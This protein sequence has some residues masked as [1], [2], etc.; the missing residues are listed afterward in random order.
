MP[1]LFDSLTIRGVTLRNRVAYAPMCQYSSTDGFATNW[2]L[3]HL[4]SR[5]VGGAGLVVTEATA[6]LPEGRISPEDL[7]IWQDAHIPKLA[8]IV[9]FVREQ[10]AELC[11]QLAHA[12][13]KASTARPWAGGELLQPEAGGWVVRAPSPLPHDER[14]GMPHELSR[15]E[16]AA[17]V[18]AFVAAAWRGVAAGCRVLEVHAA[19]GYLLHNFL[20][21]LA[22]A[23][24]DEYGG[25]FTGRTRIVREIVAGVRTVMP[26]N[27]ALLV[28]ISASDW[29]EGGWTIDDS[30]A[31]SR[32]LRAL[33]ADVIDCSS[34]GGSP[35]Q[36]IP[37]G[38]GYQVPFAERIRTEAQIATGAVGLI[39]EPA[40]ADAVIR[41]ERADLVLIGRAMMSDPYW[42]IN[43]ASAL[44]GGTDW[45]P[46][47]W[48]RNAALWSKPRTLAS[49]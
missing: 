48:R 49:S 2:H 24:S 32:D 8:E 29:T 22:N 1:G 3:V 7:G 39:V 6:V 43:A 17:T 45:P 15:A 28:R 23:R 46:Q 41:E 20:S 16:I 18:A 10:G 36:Q 4:G 21:P 37:L 40:H 19:H 11:I 26:E 5:A 38:P 14:H 25:D 9:T 33:G 30:V 44:G 13:R 35:K 27:D 31:L 47:Y 34:G 42:T 12:G